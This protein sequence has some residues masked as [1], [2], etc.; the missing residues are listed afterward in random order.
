MQ[1][2]GIVKEREKEQPHVDLFQI[3]ADVLTATIH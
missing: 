1:K 3:L 2:Y